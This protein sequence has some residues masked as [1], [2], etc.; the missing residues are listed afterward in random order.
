VT[1]SE[2]GESFFVVFLGRSVDLLLRDVQQ[3]GS[4]VVDQFGHSHCAGL[5]DC[6]SIA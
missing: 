4:I 1:F 3:Q 2:Y 6:V 5:V